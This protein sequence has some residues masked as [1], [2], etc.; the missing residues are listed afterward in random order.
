MSCCCNRFRFNFE[1]EI[2][3]RRWRYFR[4]RVAYIFHLSQEEGSLQKGSVLSRF[5]IFVC[6]FISFVK[7]SWTKGCGGYACAVEI[8]FVFSVRI[9]TSTAGKGNWGVIMESGESGEY[10]ERWSRKSNARRRVQKADSSPGFFRLVVVKRS[11]TS[12]KA[13]MM[14]LRHLHI[15]ISLHWK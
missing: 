11:S 9:S 5:D 7:Y 14:H 15:G 10:R 13:R 8:G 12:C 3:C 2:I 4:G 1:N 6:V